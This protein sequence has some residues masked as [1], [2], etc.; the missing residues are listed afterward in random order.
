MGEVALPTLTNPPETRTDRRLPVYRT[1]SL[2][3]KIKA[4]PPP[5][6]ERRHLDFPYQCSR[7]R[8]EPLWV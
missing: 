4:R 7:W 3:P 8:H 1:Y 6:A 2:L 5:P